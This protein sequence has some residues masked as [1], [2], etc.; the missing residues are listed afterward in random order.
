MDHLTSACIFLLY[1]LTHLA[2]KV[3]LPALSR[4]KKTSHSAQLY[5]THAFLTPHPHATV[6]IRVFPDFTT[7]TTELLDSF[8]RHGRSSRSSSELIKLSD[9][10]SQPIG[11]LRARG[12]SQWEAVIGSPA[13][14]IPLREA[15]LGVSA[16]STYENT[17]G[18]TAA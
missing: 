3:T 15:A 2:T 4:G 6:Y 7:K 8:K 10:P 9:R 5:Q 18:I 12:D 14:L 1:N 17:T 13:A 16:T 11:R